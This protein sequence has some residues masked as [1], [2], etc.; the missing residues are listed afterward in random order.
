MTDVLVLCYHAV[1]PD[2]PAHLSVTPE[3]FEEQLELLVRRGY[4]G[5]TFLEA[6]TAPPARRTVAITFDDAYRSVLELAL[7]IMRRLGLPGSIYVP[8]DWPGRPGPMRWEGI[9]HWVGG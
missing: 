3:H 2:W 1:S 9:D 4:R 7:P 6:I 8:T 5:A